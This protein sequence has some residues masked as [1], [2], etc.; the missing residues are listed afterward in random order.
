MQTLKRG[1]NTLP[2]LES[3]RRFEI[4]TLHDLT[5]LDAEDLIY[6]L[7]F[8]AKDIAMHTKSAPS[9]KEVAAKLREM[10]VSPIRLTTEDYDNTSYLAQTAAQKDYDLYNGGWSADY[11]DPSSYLDIFNINSGGVLQNLG[12][13]PGE[14]NDKAKVV[15][16]DVYTQMLEEANKEQDPG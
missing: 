7:G 2:V 1:I 11:Q 8:T 16:L 5:V 4:E 13:E 9:T 3:D 12:L 6:R 14:A 10:S 15:G